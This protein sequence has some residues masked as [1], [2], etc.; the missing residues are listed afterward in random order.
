MRKGLT[1][2]AVAAGAMLAGTAM[3]AEPMKIGMMVT[4]SGPPAVLGKH[5]RDGFQLY[6]DQ[7]TK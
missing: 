4:L 3:A 2:A 5:I 7:V 6:L 1:V